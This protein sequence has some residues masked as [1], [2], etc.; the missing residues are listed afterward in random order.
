MRKAAVIIDVISVNDISNY[1]DDDIQA[2]PLAV[3]TLH[4]PPPG[5]FG[6]LIGDA[7]IVFIRKFSH[8]GCKRFLFREVFLIGDANIVFIWKFSHWGCKR[9][10]LREVFLIGDANIVL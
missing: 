6:C 10:L 9:F 7:N 4:F 1:S 8:W 5:A 2:A 3:G